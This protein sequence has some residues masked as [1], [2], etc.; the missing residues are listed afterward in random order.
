MSRF[1][2]R[3]RRHSDPLKQAIGLGKCGLGK[4]ASTQRGIASD[5]RVEMR[6]ARDLS[7]DRQAAENRVQG[8]GYRLIT[9]P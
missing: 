1:A 6:R 7:A 3:A 2:S 9:A 8:A 4:A 5:R